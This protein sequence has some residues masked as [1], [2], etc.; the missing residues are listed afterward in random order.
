MKRRSLKIP[1]DDPTAQLLEAVCAETGRSRSEIVRDALRRQLRL[2][3]F[4]GLR[5]QALPFG[6]AAGWRNEDEVFAAVS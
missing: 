6:E 3:R 5:R 4:E 2:M 1:L